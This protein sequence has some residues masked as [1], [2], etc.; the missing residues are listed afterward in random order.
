M[1]GHLWHTAL[2]KEYIFFKTETFLNH[3]NA[4]GGVNKKL[5]TLE[6]F[7]SRP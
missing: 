3:T 7:L 6:S 1:A 4:E 2:I 5:T